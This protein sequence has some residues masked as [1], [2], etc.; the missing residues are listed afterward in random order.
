[1]LLHPDGISLDAVAAG[2]RQEVKILSAI[3]CTWKRL[4][5]VLKLIAEPLPRLVKIPPGFV[6][7]Y[8]RRNKQNRDPEVGLATIEAVFIAAAFLG[9]WDETLFSHY[10]F[11]KAFLDLNR[12]TFLDYG[13]ERPVTV[14]PESLDSPVTFC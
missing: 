9:H 4:G 11:G 6:T 14:L 10:A 13:V 8:P 1:M 12:G 7:A 5:S 3:D 2:Q